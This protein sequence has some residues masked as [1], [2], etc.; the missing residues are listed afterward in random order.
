MSFNSNTKIVAII[1]VKEKSE[2]VPNKN[3][4][5]FTDDG[6]SLLDLTIK[7][8]SKVNNLD[9]IYIS[10]DKADLSNSNNKNI[11]ILKRDKDYCNNV[12]PWS[13]V[14]FNVFSSIYKLIK[15]NFNDFIS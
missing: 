10:T 12:T 1:P 8:L 15:N 7:K 2:R 6:V 14:I 3:F 13:E 4:R 9:H 5:K 11:T